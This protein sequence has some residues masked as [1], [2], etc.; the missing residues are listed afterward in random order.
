MSSQQQQQQSLPQPPPSNNPIHTLFS[1]SSSSSSTGNTPPSTPANNNNTATTIPRTSSFPSIFKYHRHQ[2]NNNNNNS[3]SLLHRRNVSNLPWGT[4]LQIPEIVDGVCIREVSRVQL[5]SPAAERCGWR[6]FKSLFSIMLMLFALFGGAFGMFGVLNTNISLAVLCVVPFMIQFLKC[7]DYRIVRYRL[8]DPSLWGRLLLRLTCT[9]VLSAIVNFDARITINVLV[10]I[11]ACM[12]D[13]V[14]AFPPSL[15]VRQ[16]LMACKILG[17]MW[18]AALGISLYGDLLPK[19]REII[20][21]MGETQQYNVVLNRLCADLILVECISLIID[22]CQLWKMNPASLVHVHQSVAIY[23][24]SRFLSQI[25]ATSS[26]SLSSTN[27]NVVLNNGN[28]NRIAGTT[29]VLVPS[30]TISTNDESANV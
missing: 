22:C 4:N 25:S 19:S 10:F 7:A 3:T 5:V 23:V 20:L 15:S 14:D 18:T 12:S 6:F 26:S 8:R 11:F 29:T 1:H 21:Y 17:I 28:V 16:K 9:I 2:N 27:S 24:Q 13:I 30:L